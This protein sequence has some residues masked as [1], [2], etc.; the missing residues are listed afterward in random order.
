MASTVTRS[1]SNRAS[2]EWVMLLCQHGAKSLRNVFS[3]LLKS[4]HKELR[5]FLRQK[6]VH[7]SIRTGLNGD[8]STCG[9]LLLLR[10]AAQCFMVY[11]YVWFLIE[12]ICTLG[13][14]ATLKAIRVKQN[15]KV[16]FHKIKNELKVAKLFRRAL[17]RW[18]IAVI[19]S[20]VLL[21][22]TK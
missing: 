15:C 6:G 13:Q 10:C 18:V 16:V 4:S 3:N 21:Y 11:F 22:R 7:P 1:L 14:E 8:W 2:F 17:Q 12:F 20:L 9:L 19:V 5:K